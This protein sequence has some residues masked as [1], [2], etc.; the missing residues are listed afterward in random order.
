M[1]ISKSIK[2]NDGSYIEVPILGE[3]SVHHISDENYR[4]LLFY[5]RGL[6]PELYVFVSVEK[7]TDISSI[8]VFS[9]K[10][11]KAEIDDVASKLLPKE[12]T[13]G[14]S[15]FLTF[16]YRIREITEVPTGFLYLLCY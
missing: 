7:E 2:Y 9:N 12:Q 11:S 3:L 8:Y 15:S 13:I 16:C 1:S 14:D 10:L 6:D 5:L 4:K